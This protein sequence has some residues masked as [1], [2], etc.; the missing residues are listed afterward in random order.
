M[1]AGETYNSVVRQYVDPRMY[2]ANGAG[3]DVPVIAAAN[4]VSKRLYFS[5]G[6]YRIG[7]DYTTPRDVIWE[8]N[9]EAIIV[10][11]PGV[12][13]VIR[14]EVV[15]GLYQIFDWTESSYG[16]GADLLHEPVRIHG[17]TVVYPEWWGAKGVN[18]E[19]KSATATTSPCAGRAATSS[20]CSSL[21]G[22]GS[23]DRCGSRRGQNSKGWAITL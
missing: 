12:S 11:D 10:I 18:P 23:R 9:D 4:L 19:N 15:A 8:I 21:R 17:G 2:G 20:A 7:A 13:L 1:S 16:T 6:K 14:G 5:K 3:D 22:I